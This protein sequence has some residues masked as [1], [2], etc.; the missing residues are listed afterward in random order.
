MKSKPRREGQKKDIEEAK[1]EAIKENMQAVL[2]RLPESK[3][4][5]FHSKAVGNGEKMQ[6]IL[7]R[8]VDVY[9]SR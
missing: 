1:K 4:K 3:K 6:E 2:F 9:I 5:A 7:E 8:A